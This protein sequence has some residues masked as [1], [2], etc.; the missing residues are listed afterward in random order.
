[1]QALQS[2]RS[3]LDTAA[4]LLSFFGTISGG[5]SFPCYSSSCC[6]AFYSSLR[7]APP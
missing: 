2:L 6:C 4:E 7:K 1:M 3:K 5:G